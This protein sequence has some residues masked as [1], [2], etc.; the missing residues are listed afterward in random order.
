M[1]NLAIVVDKLMT[2]IPE[3]ETELRRRLKAAC[4]DR[5]KPPEQLWRMGASALQDRFG[6]EPP[7][8]GWGKQAVDIWMG[9]DEADEV[10]GVSGTVV[11]PSN[12]LSHTDWWFLT[13]LAALVLLGAWIVVRYG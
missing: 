9:R 4:G 8:D 3:E 6:E 7:T 2:V 1:R 11:A 10:D 5:W 13:A 12:P